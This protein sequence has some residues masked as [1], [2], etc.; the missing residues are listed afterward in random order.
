MGSSRPQA[1]RNVLGK[2]LNSKMIWRM[3]GV[4]KGVENERKN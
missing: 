2:W 4:V 1:G 3:I